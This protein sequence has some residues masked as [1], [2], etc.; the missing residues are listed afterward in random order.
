MI[1]RGLIGASKAEIEIAF[2]IRD[3][4]KAISG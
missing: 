3:A 4:D 2:V 1:R